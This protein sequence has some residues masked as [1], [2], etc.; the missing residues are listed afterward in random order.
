[1]IERFTITPEGTLGQKQLSPGNHALVQKSLG[2]I[3][4]HLKLAGQA[5][6]ENGMK[7]KLLEAQYGIAEGKSEAH[8]SGQ[9]REV[10]AG[11]HGEVLSQDELTKWVE[12][13]V[14]LGSSGPLEPYHVRMF[15]A[16]KDIQIIA[17]PPGS[18]FVKR[19]GPHT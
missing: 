7:V 1:M 10:P 8:G 9:Y 19:I 17:Y 16:P 14:P 3:T 11:S 6:F 15:L 4:A 13:I 5:K 12:V 2:L 18:P